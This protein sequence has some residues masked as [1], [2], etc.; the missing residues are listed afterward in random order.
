MKTAPVSRNFKYGRRTIAR[1]VS[2]IELMVALTLGLIILSGLGYSY[3]ATRQGFRE[4]EALSQMQEDARLAFEIMRKDILMAG[5]TGCSNDPANLP[6]MNN[7]LA[8]TGSG[9]WYQNLYT[10]ATSAPSLY[11]PLYG[12]ENSYETTIAVSAANYN[13]SFPA[14]LTGVTG[15]VAQGDVFVIK[16]A[17]TSRQFFATGQPANGPIPLNTPTYI[18]GGQILLSVPASCAGIDIFAGNSAVCTG[19]NCNSNSLPYT[20]KTGTTLLN[21]TTGS[22]IYPLSAAAYYICQPNATYNTCANTTD[23]ALY[24]QILTNNGTLSAQEVISGVQDMQVTYALD[25]DNAVDI[26]GNKTAECYVTAADLPLTGALTRGTV[27]CPAPPATPAGGA[28][29]SNVLGVRISLLL[30]SRSGEPNI[31]TQPQQYQLDNND[32]GNT[33]DAGETIAPSDQLLR[34]VFTFTFAIK[35]L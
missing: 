24:R 35:N 34:K 26:Y 12:Y 10:P 6:S 22:V 29:W 15:S 31:T 27:N 1:G 19:N 16:H 2:L 13:S 21:T 25:V 14:G 28:G 30:V 17:D 4:Q 3:V 5:Y 11:Y 7:T 8:V 23:P 9:A 20:T 32:D 18:P 33:T